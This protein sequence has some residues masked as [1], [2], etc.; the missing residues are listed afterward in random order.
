ML[1]A[2]VSFQISPTLVFHSITFSRIFEI[3][4]IFQ[5]GYVIRLC[6][7][8]VK[9]VSYKIRIFQG[10]CYTKQGFFKDRTPRI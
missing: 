4:S 8:C 10:M 7:G 3:T 9:A 6:Q 2:Q 5:Q 1:L